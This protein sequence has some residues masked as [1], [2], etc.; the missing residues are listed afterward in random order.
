LQEQ[1]VRA[2]AQLA[3]LPALVELQPCQEQQQ[4]IFGAISPRRSLPYLEED[5]G[6]SAPHS[7][8]SFISQ[9]GRWPT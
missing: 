9:I 7:G 3:S 6:L 2:Y 4:S 1:L 8:R 5:Q